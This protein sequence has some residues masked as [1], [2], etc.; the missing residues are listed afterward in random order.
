MSILR[1]VGACVGGEVPTLTPLGHHLAALP[2]DVR[3]GKMLI[4]SAILGCLE[5]MVSVWSPLTANVIS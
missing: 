4:F 5:P 3:I 1:E 2:V